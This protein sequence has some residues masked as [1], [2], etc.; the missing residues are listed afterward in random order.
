MQRFHQ[1]D[2]ESFM[3]GRQHEHAGFGHVTVNLVARH[4]TDDI[5]AFFL[6]RRAAAY[7]IEHGIRM[8]D[9]DTTEGFHQLRAALAPPVGAHKQDAL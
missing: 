8:F 3:D 9:P 6:H 5:D 4:A 7:D 1:H 2:A